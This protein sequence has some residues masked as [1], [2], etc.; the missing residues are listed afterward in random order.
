VARLF[1]GEI[2]EAQRARISLNI[3]ATTHSF[4]PNQVAEY[5]IHLGGWVHFVMT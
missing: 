1:E 5:S 2:T 4:P 3:V